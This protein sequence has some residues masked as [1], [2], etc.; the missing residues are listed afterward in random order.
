MQKYSL[1]IHKQW[2]ISMKI[3]KIIIQRKIESVNSV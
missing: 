2:I 3:W 1:I